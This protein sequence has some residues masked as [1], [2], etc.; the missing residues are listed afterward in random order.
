MK[1]IK[2]NRFFSNATLLVMIG[3][4]IISCNSGNSMT[5]AKPNIVLIMADDMGY[6]DI[7]CY[8]GEVKTPAI[9]KLASQGIRFSNF[10]NASRCCPTRASLLT[11]IYPHQAGIGDMTHAVS[12]N[13][14]PGPYQG[15]LNNNCVTLAEVLK[16]GGYYT[17]ATGKWHVGEEKPHWPTDRGFDN[18]YG[19]ISGASNYFDITRHK[20][21][22][23][24]RVFVEDGV[25][26]VPSKKGFYMTD[27]ITDH[28][29]TYLNNAKKKDK[30]FFLYVAYT[31][32]HWPL[33]ALQ[34]DIDKYRGKY[35]KGWDV[36][37][38]DRMRRMVKMGLID[39]KWA[40]SMR[41]PLVKPW[42]SLSDKQKDQM[43]MLM[44]IYAA[45]ID[46]MDQGIAKV[47][48]KLDSMGVSENTIVLFLSDNGACH[49]GGIW[50]EDFWGNFWVGKSV[51]GS[52]DSYHSVGRSWANLSN[53]PFR[54]YKH[55]IHEGGI[56]TPLIVRWPSVIHDKGTITNQV[57]NILD[58]MPTFCDISG[59]EYLKEYKGKKITEMQGK[60]L[61][62]IFEGK[63]RKQPVYYWEHEGNRAVRD[64]KWK[65]V[66]KTDSAWEL[67][68]MKEDRTEMDNLITE[69]PDNAKILIDEYEKWAERVGVKKIQIKN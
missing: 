54:M 48:A 30:P 21:N 24:K 20:N 60:S 61:L 53:T 18:Y 46:H 40:L 51:P 19:L 4:T 6:S 65:I 17:A 63:I 59:T 41:D 33:H 7:G 37:R 43:D 42:D 56:S 15:F 28:A 9:N 5:F 39:P 58:F 32:P 66:A 23:V 69:K 67:Y 29:I 10:Y 13:T 44:S 8:G 16:S 45:Q 55:W 11:G 50:G 68:D 62:P 27:A 49:E 14:V 35:M 38:E 34:K 3:M 52:G 26:I 47:L 12:S 2:F 57:G 1:K 25:S 22:T 31:A 36:L 64:G